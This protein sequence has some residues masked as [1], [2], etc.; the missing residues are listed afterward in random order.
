VLHAEL[1]RLVCV[2]GCVIV[3]NGGVMNQFVFSLGPS[4]RF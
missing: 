1:Q 3:L 2:S 4:Y